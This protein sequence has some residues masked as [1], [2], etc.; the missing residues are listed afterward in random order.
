MNENCNQCCN[1]FQKHDAEGWIQ[2]FGGKLPVHRNL[3][4]EVHFFSGKID[5]GIAESFY[6]GDKHGP[7]GIYKYRIK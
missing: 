1:P 2:W 6:W 3:I 4:V 5:S 7:Y